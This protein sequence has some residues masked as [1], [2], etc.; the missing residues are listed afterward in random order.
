MQT[1]KRCSSHQ[2]CR[3]AFA[4]SPKVSSDAYP[5]HFMAN[6][7]TKAASQPQYVVN[8]AAV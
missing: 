2:P 4:N 5:V 3:L 1:P 7:L 6:A 8:T